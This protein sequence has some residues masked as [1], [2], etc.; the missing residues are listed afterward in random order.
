MWEPEQT[1]TYEVTIAAPAAH[2]SWTGTLPG[3]AILDWRAGDDGTRVITFV[4]QRWMASDF[5]AAIRMARAVQSY[6][7]G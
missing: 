1:L 3:S 7:Q 2:P 6:R 4:V 5:A